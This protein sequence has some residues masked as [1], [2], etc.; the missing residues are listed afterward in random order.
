MDPRDAEHRQDSPGIRTNPRVTTEAGSASSRHAFRRG[1]ATRPRPVTVYMGA[2][3]SIASAG[4][5]TGKPR[6]RAKT[7]PQP[8]G[9]HRPPLQRTIKKGAAE[10]PSP[11]FGGLPSGA[12]SA[13]TSRFIEVVNL[14]ISASNNLPW[15]VRFFEFC[16]PLFA[17]LT[18][19]EE[20]C[21]SEAIISCWTRPRSSTGVFTHTLVVELQNCALASSAAR[22]LH[23]LRFLDER[24]EARVIVSP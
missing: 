9:R 21:D 11:D 20:D 7:M 5:V 3:S 18:D 24:V 16:N 10:A 4:T 22:V 2:S 12:S 15:S 1:S 8:P 13:L 23:G 6:I 19:F 17:K 14:P